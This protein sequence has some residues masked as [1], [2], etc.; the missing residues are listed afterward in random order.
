MFPFFD[1]Q[2]WFYCIG[3]IITPLSLTPATDLFSLFPFLKNDFFTVS[4]PRPFL[5]TFEQTVAAVS[6]A[7]SDAFLRSC[8][9]AGFCLL[10]DFHLLS[11]CLLF[12]PVTSSFVLDLASFLIFFFPYFK[13]CTCHI[14]T[15]FTRSPCWCIFCQSNCPTVGIFIRFD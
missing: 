5:V 8:V 12:M 11:I 15:R 9:F 7:G 1:I 3:K 10:H 2:A 6:A 13:P 14:L 4:L